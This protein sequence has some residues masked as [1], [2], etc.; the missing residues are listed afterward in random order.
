MSL[1]IADPL[2]YAVF[3]IMNTE[4]ANNTIRVDRKE[5]G[6]VACLQVKNAAS[7]ILDLSRTSSGAIS[8]GLTGI[9]NG[10][11]TA[12][13]TSKVFDT[14]CKSVN[15]ISKLVNPILVVAS[16]HRAWKAEDKKSAFLKEFGAMSF[17]LGGEYIYK[18][19]FGLGGK[20]ATYKN[21]KALAVAINGAKQF[22]KSN[23]FLKNLPMGKVGGLVKAL[24]FI[25]TSCGMFELGSRL[26]QTIA[27]KTTA[28]TYAKKHEIKPETKTSTEEQKQEN[29]LETNA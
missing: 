18:S 16:I 13:S 19:L 25:A 23:R 3:G 6:L 1:N 7:D 15:F 27:N 11:H 5:R 4:K 8:E 21:H 9:S 12:R 22:V 29:K 20:V 28:K 24:G 14:V 17:M 10:I 26:G 2:R